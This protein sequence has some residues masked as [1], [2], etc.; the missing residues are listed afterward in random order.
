MKSFNEVSL[1]G[2]KWVQR[3]STE[4]ELISGDDVV[5]ALHWASRWSSLATAES[6]D[7]NW[8][9]KRA[10]FIHP[11]ITI[12]KIDQD[13]DL[14]TADV[15]WR[16]EATLMLPSQGAFQWKPNFWNNKWT[17]FDNNGKEM[18]RIELGGFVNVSGNV[19]IEQTS[20]ATPTLSLLALLGW[21]L[22]MNVLSD[23]VVISAGAIAAAD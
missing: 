12:R 23:E 13:V 18:M 8:T 14:Y 1:K 10:G 15:G 3:S 6:A 17:L 19:T 16:G 4:D 21:H 9:F 2:L 11:K 7:G 22:I 20:I 5:G